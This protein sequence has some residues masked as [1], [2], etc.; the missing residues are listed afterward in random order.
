[1]AHPKTGDVVS[2]HYTCKVENGDIFET[3]IEKEPLKFK[4]GDGTVIHGLEEAV[5]DMQPDESK[6]VKIPPEKGYGQRKEELIQTIDKS[7]LP[8]NI[9]PKPGT[10]LTIKNKEGK[11]ERLFVRDVSDNEVTLDANHP[12]AGQTLIYDL[13]LIEIQS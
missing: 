9:H 2:V 4:I 3:S 1:M 8:E 6:T 5:L 12:L 7:R 13:I 11:K 10:Y